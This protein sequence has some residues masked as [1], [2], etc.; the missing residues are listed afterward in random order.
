MCI[1]L[2]VFLVLAFSVI[3]HA[4]SQPSPSPYPNAV[5][6]ARQRFACSD[7]YTQGTCDHQMAVLRTILTRFKSER[8]GGWTWVLV[9]SDEWDRIKK[10]RGL[11]SASPAFTVLSLRQTFFE[12]ALLSPVPRRTPELMEVWGRSIDELLVL[13]V[14]HEL[15][16]AICKE[17]DEKRADTYGAQLRAGE[18]IACR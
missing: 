13:A 12:E 3:E 18:E 8:A 16:H 10:A 14:S 9:R 1:R 17:T 6:W 5:S 11:T 2:L 4:S 15:G 7:G